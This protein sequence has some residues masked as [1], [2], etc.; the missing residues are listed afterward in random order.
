MA[1][2]SDPIVKLLQPDFHCVERLPNCFE[3][4]R[5]SDN[6]L[7]ANG[8][9]EVEAWAHAIDVLRVGQRPL[10]CETRVRAVARLIMQSAFA[11]DVKDLT[12]KLWTSEYIGDAHWRRAVLTARAVLQMEMSGCEVE[13]EI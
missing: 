5:T 4:I 2:F 8:A 11:D 7:F 1:E 9:T 12:S 13:V 6:K 10:D 3:V